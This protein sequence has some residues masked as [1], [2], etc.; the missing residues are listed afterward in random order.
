VIQLRLKNVFAELKNG[1]IGRDVDYQR[2]SQ[3]IEPVTNPEITTDWP[4]ELDMKF[5]KPWL[6]G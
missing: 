3:P 2:N 6:K 4:T 1:Q 5:E